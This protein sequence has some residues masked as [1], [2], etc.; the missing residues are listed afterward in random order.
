MGLSKRTKSHQVREDRRINKRRGDEGAQR[1]AGWR[2][3]GEYR[4]ERQNRK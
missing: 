1:V 3:K 2:E 4:K